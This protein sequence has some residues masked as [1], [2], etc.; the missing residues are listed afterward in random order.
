MHEEKNA[1]SE[2]EEICRQQYEEIEK[3]KLQLWDVE[4]EN[5]VLRSS[6]D[7][8]QK[9]VEKHVNR[10]DDLER[11]C[12]HLQSII[13]K[14]AEER[15]KRESQYQMLAERFGIFF[16]IARKIKRMLVG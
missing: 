8:Y 11:W 7:E 9:T 5:R 13:D 6:I 10:I 15:K 12:S 1:W 14:E 4:E 2:L 3:K 16:K